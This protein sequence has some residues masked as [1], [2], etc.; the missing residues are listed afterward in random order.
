MTIS[1]QRRD[2]LLGPAEGML[3]TALMIQRLISD[4]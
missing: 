4:P 1:S 2:A 3:M